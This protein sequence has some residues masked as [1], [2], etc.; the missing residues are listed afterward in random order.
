MSAVHG[1]YNLRLLGKVPYQDTSERSLAL[2]YS[3]P[4]SVTVS[5]SA[6]SLPRTGSSADSGTFGSADQKF[7]LLIR[8]SGGKRRQHVARLEFVDIVNNPLVP[9]QTMPVSAA[10]TFTVNRPLTGIDAAQAQAIAKGLT[11]WL[12]DANVGK[13]IGQEI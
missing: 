10:V 4:Q 8:H 13:L 9:S 7:K 6:T 12:T 11:A 1:E 3:D 5:G 2:A